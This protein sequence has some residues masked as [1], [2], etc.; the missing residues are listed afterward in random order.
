MLFGLGF[1]HILQ[2]FINPAKSSRYFSGFLN[3]LAQLFHIFTQ[4]VKNRAQT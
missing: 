3:F 2:F 1:A 4:T